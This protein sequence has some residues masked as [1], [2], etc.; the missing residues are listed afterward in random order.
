[1]QKRI[2]FVFCFVSIFKT[3]SYMYTHHHHVSI[4]TC[5][6]F[7]RIC[8]MEHPV[9]VYA[10]KLQRMILELPFVLSSTRRLLACRTMCLRSY[11]W[12][13]I[14]HNRCRWCC[15]FAAKRSHLV[16]FIRKDQRWR[17]IYRRYM[18]IWR[19]LQLC[20]SW[21]RTTI[22]KVDFWLWCCQLHQACSQP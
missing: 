10:L 5:C 1:M 13:C 19:N 7:L 6:R 11:R 17:S 20:N 8:R 22:P 9:W 14:C 21:R 4:L 12:S 16:R 3:L 2:N 18:G 15:S